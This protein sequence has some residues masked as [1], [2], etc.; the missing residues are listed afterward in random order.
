MTRE[1]KSQSLEEL[2]KLPWSRELVP[3]GPTVAARVPELPG[4]FAEGNDLAEALANLEDALEAW[5]A[6]ALELGN[7][8]PRPRGEAEPE[9]FSGRFS[10]RVPK[11]LHRRL[12]ALADGEGCS[13]NQLVVTVLAEAVH[14]PVRSAGETEMTRED[15]AADAIGQGPQAI[16]AL[17]GI[18]THIRNRGDVNLACVLYALAGERTALEAGGAQLAAREFGTAGAL[19]RR[20]RK[21]KMAEALWRE[22]LR[23]DFTNI[24]SRSSLGQLLHHQGRFGEAIEYLEPVA[25]VDDYARL[26]LGWSQLQLGLSDRSEHLVVD[27]L[28]NVVAGLRRWA[29]Y[30]N[31]SDRTPWLRQVQRLA[32]LGKRFDP[33]VEQLVSF[34]N[35]NSNWRSISVD[36]VVQASVDDGDDE[37]APDVPA[38]V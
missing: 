35:S 15:I 36:E 5:L 37:L 9:S 31:D 19:A 30:A 29:A 33:E 7:E 38:A 16:G 27:G 23:R 2:V 8:V 12:A 1:T 25:D 32:R 21:L 24:R 6:S 22:S 14:L 20:E 10:V 4:C 3:D 34:A 26:F 18:A 28:S 13:L 11:T 17:K